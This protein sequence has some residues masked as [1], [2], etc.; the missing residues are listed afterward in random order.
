[1]SEFK[2]IPGS[3]IQI[4]PATWHDLRELYQLERVC[5]QVDAWPMLDILGVLTLPQV[6]RLKAADENMLIG[7]IAADLRRTQQT[8]WI[9]TLAVLPQYQKAGLGSALL[10]ACESQITLPRIRLSVRQSNHPAIQLYKKHS[11][12]QVDTWSGYYKG[13]D[14]ALV[15]EKILVTSGL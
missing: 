12:Q 10:E 11:Y 13:G 5:F 7:F 15:F 6:L 4:M 3:G 2:T 8:A 9:A 14:D 1:M